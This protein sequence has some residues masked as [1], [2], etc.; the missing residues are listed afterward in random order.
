MNEA[1]TKITAAVEQKIMQS[2]HVAQMMIKAGNEKLQE[3][4]K[5]LDL[6]LAN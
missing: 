1:S 3:T 5:K 6:I 2:V 4:S